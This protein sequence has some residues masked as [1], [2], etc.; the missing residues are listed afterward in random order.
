MKLDADLVSLLHR[1]E[2]HPSEP[3]SEIAEAE[4][5]KLIITLMLQLQSKRDE[6]HELKKLLGGSGTY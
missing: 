5:Y 4:A 6:C 3:R 1:L 2:L